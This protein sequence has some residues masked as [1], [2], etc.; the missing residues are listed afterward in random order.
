MPEK[1]TTFP[2]GTLLKLLGYHQVLFVKWLILT[3]S[4]II[5]L[6][7]TNECSIELLCRNSLILYLLMLKNKKIIAKLTTSMQGYHLKNNLMIFI[8]KFNSCKPENL[9]ILIIP[10]LQMWLQE[11]ISKEKVLKPFW[12]PAYKELS[13]KLL[14]PTVIDCVD[15]D[16]NYYNSLSNVPVVTLPLLTIRLIKPQNNYS[17][18]TYCPLSTFIPAE[19]WVQEDTTTKG[20]KLLLK[21]SN[22]QKIIIDEWFNT[23]NYV[24]NKTVA[25]INKP[26]KKVN[27]I[28]LRD[29]FVTNNTKKNNPQYKEI[30][31]ELE[32]LHKSLIGLSKNDD[33]YKF[34]TNKINEQKIK[35]SKIVKELPSEKNTNI[36]DWELKTPKDIRA[37]AVDDVCKAHKTGI[38]NLMNGNI[39]YFNLGFRKKTSKEK[40]IVI[41]K[42]MIKNNDG[43]ITIAKTYLKEHS[44]IKMID[45]DKKKYK[46][47]NIQNDCRI[48]KSYGEYY[49]I[50]PLVSKINK[51]KTDELKYCGID[52]G[53]RTFMTCFTNNGCYEYEHDRNVIEILNKKIDK[54]K[55][56]KYNKPYIKR[57]RKRNIR[58]Y[59]VK[60]E[61]II[62][63]IH[64]KTILHLLKENDYIFY[65]DIKSHDIVRK[66]KNSKLNRNLNDLRLYKFKER[67]VYK[68]KEKGKH[69]SL[70]NESYTTQ[71]C[72][73]CGK[74]NKPGCSKIYSCSD[75]KIKTG[76]DVNASKNILMKGILTLSSCK[77]KSTI[78]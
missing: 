61:N 74:I 12:T 38:T 18:K 63:E 11:L 65:G 34:I 21:L 19:K 72:S 20:L 35:L 9:N 14:L 23:S 13:E 36:K 58:K 28:A 71:T 49:L 50:V 52:P 78:Y 54:M 67:L 5:K 56:K 16:T 26:N 69:V 62:N 47:L 7:T 37:G 44:T 3:K 66:G 1:L 43:T 41:P 24:Y 15:S 40:C 31:D 73:F 4:N 30:T 53:E 39:K 2:S 70:V 51:V 25:E 48:I 29:K 42:S 77:E 8:D 17:Q 64:W 10:L 27:F 22:P 59:E 33:K 75:C 60:K 32:K 68:A 57:S 45:K 55:N 6:S 76:R 46:N